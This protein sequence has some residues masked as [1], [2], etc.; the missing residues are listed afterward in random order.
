MVFQGLQLTTESDVEQKV[1]MPLLATEQYLA[2]PSTSIQTKEYLPPTN[3]DKAAGKSSGYFPDYSV[4]SYG[5]PVMIVEAK[6]PGVSPDVGYREA[7]L[8]ARH[9]NQSYPSDLNPCLIIVA[10]N[11]EELLCGT[12]DSSPKLRLRVDLLMP[13]SIGTEELQK[14]CSASVLQQHAVKIS[15]ALRAKRIFPPFEAMGGQ[16]VLNARL[17]PNSFAKE[18][19]PILRRYFSSTAHEN[20][21]EIAR[22]AYISSDEATEYDK[23]LGSL[24]RVAGTIICTNQRQRQSKIEV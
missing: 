8:Y 4:W 15:N 23:I 19:S 11:G 10:T 16:P 21:H 1:I 2:F 17:A 7:S 24:L 20:I 13:G 9:L 3:L 18:L 22:T 5:L 12:W 14:M 6:A